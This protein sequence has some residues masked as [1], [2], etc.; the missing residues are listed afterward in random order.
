M[1]EK[2][3]AVLDVIRANPY[4]SQQE[5]AD[6]LQ[7]SRP[8]LA[9]IISGL[10]KQGKIL[11]RAYILPEDT[12]I[13]CIGGA[14]IDRKFHLNG[15]TQLGTS[16]PASMG[17]S[18]GGVA[19]NIAENLGRLDHHV[20]LLTVAGNDSD[21]DLI[22]GESSSYMDLS[23]VGQLIGKSTGSYSAVLDPEGELVIAMANMEV[24]DSLTPAYL[25]EKSRI[26]SNAS[27]IVI[28]LNCPKESVDYIKNLANQ[29]GNSL[30]IIPVSSPKMNRMP[31]DLKGVT[32]FICNRDEAETYTGLT[33]GNEADWKKAVHELL[34]F[35]AENVVV[36]AGAR[37][38]MAATAGGE[39]I[40]FP[41]VEDVHVEDVT[42]A[43]DAFVS[44]LLHGHL[45]E[46]T[47][48]ESVRMGLLN[49]AKTLESSFT[50]R[51]ELTIDLLNKELEELR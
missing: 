19:R 9:N 10:I 50:V 40:H 2:E 42:G 7:I 36:T 47:L 21:W 15:R 49:A 13:I 30:V 33:I 45:V 37:G 48:E 8:S 4:L 1:N 14:N 44:G 32:W 23:D 22:V 17:V 18:V 12:E 34:A 16:N 41:A 35:G 43:G 6:A 26:I 29:N 3:R 25:E 24:Y 20:R 28:D 31:S 39:P 46:G 51:P 5:M 27:L 11:G 38:I